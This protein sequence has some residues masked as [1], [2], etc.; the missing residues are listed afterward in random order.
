MTENKKIKYAVVITEMQADY[1]DEKLIG[2]TEISKKLLM[3][4][5]E[6]QAEEALVSYYESQD[7]DYKVE[8]QKIGYVGA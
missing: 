6:N 2:W 8:V 3:F 1:E 5:D 4:D 7:C